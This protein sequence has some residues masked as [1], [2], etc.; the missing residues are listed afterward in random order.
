MA[1]SSLQNLTHPFPHP[2]SARRCDTF[3]TRLRGFMFRTTIQP[4][5]ALLFIQPAENRVD[6]AIHMFFVP[7]AL[8]VIWMDSAGKVVD[9]CIAHPWRPYYAPEKPARYILETH[10]DKLSLFHTG[11]QI[12]ID[13]A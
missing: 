3:F 5:E 7:F 2:V 9:T 8:G 13:H 10:P 4:D 11:D 1:L 12:R 6:A